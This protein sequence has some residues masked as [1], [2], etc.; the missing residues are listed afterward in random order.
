MCVWHVCA[1]FGSVVF[2]LEIPQN[3]RFQPHYFVSFRF[4]D[5]STLH[6]QIK[7]AP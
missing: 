4:F 2:R 6:T 3:K 7:P 1:L 5:R